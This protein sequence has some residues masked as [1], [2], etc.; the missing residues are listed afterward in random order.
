M[1]QLFPPVSSWRTSEVI[2]LWLGSLVGGPLGIVLGW[3]LSGYFVEAFILSDPTE[4]PSDDPL[5]GFGIIL[6]SAALAGLI[7][8]VLA[9]WIPLRLIH[10]PRAGP[11]A[12]V[13]FLLMIVLVPLTAGV[14]SILLPVNI[15]IGIH[16]ALLVATIASLVCA[17]LTYVFVTSRGKRDLVV[18]PA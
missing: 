13:S 11:S 16:S 2:S 8:A 5:E 4:F 14:G 3:T 7:G 1:R 12:L 18:E 17:V 9:V 6:Y 10:A 15:G